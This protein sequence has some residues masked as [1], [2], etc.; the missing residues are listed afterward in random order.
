MGIFT[1][2]IKFVSNQLQE[3]NTFALVEVTKTATFKELSRTDKDQH[4][5]PFMMAAL[6]EVSGKNTAKI[7]DQQL[8]DLTVKCIDTLLIEDETFTSQ[9]KTE[10]MNDS[11]AIFKFG[12]WLMGEKI[13]PFFQN[14]MAS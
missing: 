11:F 2:E 7:S 13:T 4:M 5:L 12:W 9:D 8:Y 10:F 1:K 3:D 6:F 14:L